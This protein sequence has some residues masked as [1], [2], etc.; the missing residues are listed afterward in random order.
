MS[1]LFGEAVRALGKFRF[2][3]F[4]FCNTRQFV[5]RTGYSSQDG[6]EI[7]LEG[8][9]HGEKLWDAVLDA[10]QPYSIAPG[11]P[12][13]IDRIEAGLISYGNEV[14]RENNPLEAGLER[15]CALDRDIDCLGLPALRKLAEQGIRRRLKGI[16]FGGD[17]R[18]PR[19]EPFPVLADDSSGRKIGM[20]TSS[21]YSPRLERNVGLAMM[22][23][24]YWLAGEFVIVRI[25]ERQFT[26][27]EISDLPFD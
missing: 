16:H 19:A 18:P 9:S 2:G 24:P 17:M 1:A 7:F 10:G 25:G 27:G 13:L 22:E 3:E 4:E 23:N 11:C 6:F 15:F 14:T 12:N 21:A 20:V 8:G 26:Q 5:S